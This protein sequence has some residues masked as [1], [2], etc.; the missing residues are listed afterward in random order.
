MSDSSQLLLK[1][2]EFKSQADEILKKT[3][4]VELF[5]TYGEVKM[6][7][8]YPLDVMLR[9]DLDIYV[10]VKEHSYAKVVEIITSLLSLNYFQQ[11]CFA[12]WLDHSREKGL[13]GYYLE[14]KVNIGG[15]R[16]KLDIWF[17]TED[18]YK[19]HTEKF[20]ELLKNNENADKLRLKIL[21]L[22]NHYRE[23]DKYQGNINGKL[24]YKAVLEHGVR[25]VEQFENYVKTE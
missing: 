5:S 17:M 10:L 18:Q 14:P 20:L 23:G 12:N 9:E 3:K 4:I 19:F 13:K 22:K 25:T 15:N 6:V 7:G 16:W 8:S 1:S 2:K 11:I 21:E 24:I